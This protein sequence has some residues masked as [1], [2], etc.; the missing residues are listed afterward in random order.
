MKLIFTPILLIT[1]IARSQGVLDFNSIA[2]ESSESLEVFG[3]TKPDFKWDMEGRVQAALND[4]INYLDEGSPALALPQLREAVNRAPNLWVAHYFEGVCLKQLKRPVEAE[5]EF[6][7][8]NELSDK[9]ILNYIELGKTT[10]LMDYAKAEQWFKKA[11]KIDPA[12]P[13]PVYMLANHYMRA[14]YFDDAKKLYKQCLEMDPH[15]LDAEVKLAMIDVQVS[16]S[17]NSKNAIKYL[18]D[19]LAKDSLHKQAL[20]F[21]G[22][23]KIRDSRVSLEDFNRLVRISPGN[24]TFRFIRGL[25]Y[26]QNTQY[27]PAFSDLRKVVDAAQINANK[28]VGQQSNLDKRIDIQYAGFLCCIKCL[29]PPRLRC[30]SLEESL[31]FTISRSLRRSF[32][33]HRRS[34]GMAQICVVSF[35]EGHC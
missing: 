25:L 17:V 10:G 16:K 33:D 23:L 29:R 15:M 30:V 14:R 2:E 22:L 8:V 26:A 6:L 12:D 31:L 27:E 7:R 24:M 32:V 18:E 20:I 21:H 9:N 35:Y 5:K 28:F 13:R 19:V 34:E 3:Y 1:I 11:A 4:G